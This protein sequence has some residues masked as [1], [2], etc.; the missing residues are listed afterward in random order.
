ME[1]LG[2]KR[3]ETDR[4]VLRQFTMADADAMYRNWACDPEVTKYLRWPHHAS[5]EVSRDVLRDWTSHYA[6]PGFYNWAIVL[7]ENGP[8]PIGSIG[9]VE[10]DDAIRMVHIGYCLGRRW[11]RQGIMTEALAAMLQFFFGQV[12]VNRVESRHDPRNPN[13]GRVMQAC[14][15]RYEGAHRQ[16]DWSNQGIC[17]SVWY[18]ILAKDG[19][20]PDVLV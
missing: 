18:A 7:K 2:T 16:D 20:P 19:P 12:G 4:L 14:G 6:E 9:V 13:S 15:M 11:W 10:R 1:H 8:E 5:V 3:L 17:D